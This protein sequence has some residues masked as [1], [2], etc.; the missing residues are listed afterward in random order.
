MNSRCAVVSPGDRVLVKVVA[1]QGKHKIADKWER[2]PY[3]II[4]QPNQDIP[5][6]K[7]QREDG[8]GKV[9]TLHR[10]LLLPIGSL[11][12]GKE[13]DSII[14]TKVK[15]HKDSKPVSPST[16]PARKRPGKPIPEYEASREEEGTVSE[17]HS[18]EEQFRRQTPV[19]VELPEHGDSQA[20]VEQS[21]G[22][23]TGTESIHE[24]EELEPLHIS[25]HDDDSE[26]SDEIPVSTSHTSGAETC[27]PKDKSVSTTT[28]ST[29]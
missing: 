10:N 8:V 5:V 23:S 9:R 16:Q 17:S 21:D 19:F 14:K 27:C 22:N 4:S 20:V 18:D 12:I 15:T 6:Y 28:C 24:Q 2:D 11:P 7:L 26:A 3:K 25:D 13:E 29:E 1:F